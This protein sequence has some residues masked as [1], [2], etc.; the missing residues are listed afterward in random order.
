MQDIVGDV[1]DFIEKK[2][3]VFYSDVSREFKIAN[4][5]VKDIVT[6]LE[7]EGI[8]TIE[9]KGIAKLVKRK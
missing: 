2:G 7:R 6:I 1:K 3:V 9:D 8:V 5:T 4:Q